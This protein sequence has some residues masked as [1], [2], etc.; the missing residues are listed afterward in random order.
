MNAVDTNVLLYV[1]DARNPD[2]QLKAIQLIEQLGD[3]VCL[4]QVA[5]EYLAASRKLAPQGLTLEIAWRDIE[6]YIK[7]WVLIEPSK[8]VLTQAVDLCKHYSL[9]YWDAMLV[10]ACA[11]AGVTRLYSEDLGSMSYGVI[12]GVSLVN[13]FA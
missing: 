11:D 6:D 13:P 8:A 9:S 12:E 3:C 7:D 4:W 1:R 2:K 5:C 10:A